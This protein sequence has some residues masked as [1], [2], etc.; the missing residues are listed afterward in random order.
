MMFACGYYFVPRALSPISDSGNACTALVTT[1]LANWF[2]G[3]KLSARV[4]RVCSGRRKICV[5]RFEGF[6]F[7]G[8]L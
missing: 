8:R 4:D 6:P 5:G 3:L 7:V 2:T 1:K